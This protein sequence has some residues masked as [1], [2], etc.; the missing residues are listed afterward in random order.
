M[1]DLVPLTLQGRGTRSYRVDQPVYV[2]RG[3]ES[4]PERIS[5]SEVAPGDYIGISYGGQWASSPAGLPPLVHR[6]RTGSEKRIR[7][8]TQMSTDLA[9]FLGA[10]LSEGHTT[11]SN[12]SVI[13]TNSVPEV[14]LEV[15]RCAKEV[16]GLDG[17]LTAQPGRCTGLVV[18]SKRLVEFM[19][20][21]GCGTRASNKTVPAAILDGTREHAIRFMQGAALDAYTAHSH[22]GKWGICLESH[23]AI[24]GLQDV[25]TKLGIVNSQI[26]KFNKQVQKTYF[27][28]YSPGPWG[29]Q[30]ARLAPFLVP[31]KLLRAEEYCSREY[32]SALADRIPGITGPELYTLV[33]AGRCGRNGRGTGRQ[34]FR[35]LR[36][37]RSRH[38]TRGSVKQAQAAG[39]QLPT[40]LAEVLRQDIRFSRAVPT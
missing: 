4:P 25:V 9:L 31:D 21:L 22:A 39:A 32:R 13:F 15:Q 29:Q 27:E 20:H 19:K 7:V 11:R 40:W 30:L 18:S 5:P 34:Q 16:F 1:T 28:L 37:P 36:D 38:V 23:A 8:P 17:R 24:D 2:S 12:W 6:P 3:G 35:H 14:L 33:P 10:Y 26:P